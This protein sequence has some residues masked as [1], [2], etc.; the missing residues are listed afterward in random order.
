[1]RTPST[2]KRICVLVLI[3]YPKNEIRIIPE[4]IMHA[5]RNLWSRCFSEK[6]QPPRMTAKSAEADLKALV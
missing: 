5:Q 6:N 1:M 3:N 4:R 2:S